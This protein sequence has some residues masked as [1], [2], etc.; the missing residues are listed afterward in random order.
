LIVIDDTC[1]H[2]LLLDIEVVLRLSKCS[3]QLLSLFSGTSLEP[4]ALISTLLPSLYLGAELLI[5][6]LNKL[7]V[8]DATES[9]L[10]TVPLF[11][12][13]IDCLQVK[14]EVPQ[15]NLILGQDLGVRFSSFGIIVLSQRGFSLDC[16][17]IGVQLFA[18]K[19]KEIT[20]FTL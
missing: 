13:G 16:G 8:E 14:P 5:A 2:H 6:L 19:E 12:H 15:F 1:D 9:L 10:L 7:H 4:F 20:Y 11:K 3:F 18:E 17:L